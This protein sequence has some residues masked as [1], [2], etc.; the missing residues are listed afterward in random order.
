VQRTLNGLTY[1]PYSVY[2]Q[3]QQRPAARV[4]PVVNASGV[5]VAPSRASIADGSYELARPLLLFVRGRAERATGVDGFVGLVLTTA[6][7]RLA[8]LDFLP[9]SRAET[10]LAVFVLRGLDEAAPLDLSTQDVLSA[11][12]IL[13]QQ[14]PPHRREQ[15]RS[16]LESN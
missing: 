5:A 14:L 4:I 11:R 15:A 12:G 7:R 1:L 6:E 13:L 2:L 8:D 3:F 9:L 16:K 10:E